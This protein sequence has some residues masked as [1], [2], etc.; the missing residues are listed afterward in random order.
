MDM[1]KGTL[2]FFTGLAGAGK[3]TLG[4]LFYEKLKMIHSDA[5]LMD[6]DQRRADAAPVNPKAKDY[7]T[8]AR[9]QGAR[10]MFGDCKDLTDQGYDVV[11]CSISMYDEIREWNR[12]NIEEY[13][14]I[15]VKASMETL[16]RRDQKGLYTSGAKNVVGLDLPW[17]EPKTPDIVVEN[18]GS[19]APEAIVERIVDVFGLRR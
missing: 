16:T 19:E 5:I 11:C 9:L 13:K 8:E 1:Q 3:S 12:A 2:Y 4:G 18:D 15:Y 14:E 6:G 7:S 10:V 17:D